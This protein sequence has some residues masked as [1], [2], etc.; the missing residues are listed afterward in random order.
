MLGLG[1]LIAQDGQLVLDKRMP[2]NSQA[3]KFLYML[4]HSVSGDR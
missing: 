3:G 4:Y 1:A 2:D